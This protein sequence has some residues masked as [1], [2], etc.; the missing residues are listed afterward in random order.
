M[1]NCFYCGVEL[2]PKGTTKAQRKALGAKT[3]YETDDH[4]MPRSITGQSR[5]SRTGTVPSCQPCNNNKHSLTLEEYRV[6]L[7][8]RYGYISGVQ[9]QFPGEEIPAYDI[10]PD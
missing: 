5:N 6:V 3:F 2:V 10:V 4:M 8:F 9:Y 1:I 7:A